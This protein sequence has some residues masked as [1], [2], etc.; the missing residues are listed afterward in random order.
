MKEAAQ[1]DELNLFKKK[2]PEPIKSEPESSPNDYH[3]YFNK[4]SKPAQKVYSHPGEYYAKTKIDPL[5]VKEPVSELDDGDVDESQSSDMRDF[6]STQKPLNPSMPISNPTG[7]T[8]GRV[9]RQS[10]GVNEITK[11]AAVK[12]YKDIQNYK[13]DNRKSKPDPEKEF[14]KITVN[15]PKKE[16]GVAESTD[17]IDEK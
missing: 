2:K 4:P 15:R 6:F 16:Q 17:Y 3:A 13:L 11:Q 5:K 10:E 14:L 1:L 8:V 12:Q 7:P 9:T